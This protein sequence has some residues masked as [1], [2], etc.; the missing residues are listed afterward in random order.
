MTITDIRPR[1]KGLSQLYIDGEEA[2][3]LD[4]FT[5]EKYGIKAGQTITDEELYDLIQN[6]EKHRASEKALYL[7]EHR[8]RSKKELVDKISEVASK[9]IAIEAADHMEEIGLVNDREFAHMF[10]RQLFGFKRYGS[11]RVRQELR[12]KGIDPEI[13]DEV[14]A[15]YDNDPT[16]KI[17]EVIRK[18]YPKFAEDEKIRRRAVAALQRLGYTYEEIRSALG[19][20]DESEYFD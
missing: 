6:S 15:E 9:E 16:E 19:S 4:T 7:L 18:K 14:I 3:K 11:R 20:F 1:R 17:H 13:I 5:L 8:A 12:I 2:M 10:A